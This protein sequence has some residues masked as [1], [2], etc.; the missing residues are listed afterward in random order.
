MRASH[1][2]LY[3]LFCAC[4][5][6]SSFDR[7]FD[8]GID[9]RV[10]TVDASSDA[11]SFGGDARADAASCKSSLTGVI[12]DFKPSHP[13]FERFVGTNAFLG[14][15]ASTL[16][17]DGKPVYAH[18]GG[19]AVTTGKAEFDQWYRDVAGV[20]VALPIDLPLVES[21][22]GVFTYDN[23]S[24]FP[25]DGQGYGNGPQ[26]AHNFLFTTEVHLRFTY[27]GGEVF[28]FRGDDDLWVFIDG[29]LVIDL[30]GSHPQLAG[31]VALDTAGLVKGR[32]YPM[33][34]FHAERHTDRSTFHV[35]TTIQCLTPR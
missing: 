5:S 6:A 18:A 30:G 12:R 2:V 28:A 1:V 3:G 7:T 8:A 35:E 15:V 31:S 33:D 25:I 13:D 27:R 26:P 4:G 20:N 16:G 14:I 17:P 24:F 23:D 29:K 34:L 19:T 32:Q 11:P 22:P 10:E 21:K 9:A